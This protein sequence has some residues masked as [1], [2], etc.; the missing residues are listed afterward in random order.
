MNKERHQQK[1]DR[2]WCKQDVMSFTEWFAVAMSD[3][4]QQI[5]TEIKLIL[6]YSGSIEHK[7]KPFGN[8]RPSGITR[9]V[10]ELRELN[11]KRSGVT[12]KEAACLRKSRDTM[13]REVRVTWEDLT[14]EQLE[15]IYERLKSSLT[16]IDSALF[17][18]LDEGLRKSPK[19]NALEQRNAVKANLRCH[20]YAD[21]ENANRGKVDFYGTEIVDETGVCYGEFV[22]PERDATVKSY[23]KVGYMRSTPLSIQARDAKMELEQRRKDLSR[24]STVTY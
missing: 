15:V 6:T 22:E 18:Y 20:Y 7:A 3:I 12:Q 11:D 16:N 24:R 1:Y 4:T 23:R 2:L 13:E 17:I 14:S 9:V 5:N 19:S 8:Y 10:K 21:V